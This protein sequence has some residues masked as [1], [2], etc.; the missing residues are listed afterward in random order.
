MANLYFTFQNKATPFTL[1][2]PIPYNQDMAHIARAFGLMP[3]PQLVNT[4]TQY[5]ANLT[6]TANPNVYNAVF[7]AFPTTGR[8]GV[9]LYLRFPSAPVGTAIQIS[10]TVGTTT[11]GPF[12]IT[13]VSG[14]AYPPG[15]F[16]GDV[17][18][19]TVFRDN[20]T[21]QLLGAGST[22]LSAVAAATVSVATK[23]TEATNSA[24]TAASA[25]MAAQDSANTILFTD[26]PAVYAQIN[27]LAL[28]QATPTV[29]GQVTLPL[30]V[31]VASPFPT[32]ALR[33][34]A[35]V[36]IYQG[37]LGKAAINH[38]HPA[39][40]IVPSGAT[41]DARGFVQLNSTLTSA[42]VTQAAT[43]SA[44]NALLGVLN[45]KAAVNHTHSFDAIQ[46]P[47]ATTTTAGIVQLSDSTTSTSATLASTITAMR[48]VNT[49]LS[50]KADV[51]HTHPLSDVGAPSASTSQ[52]GLVR[53]NDTLVSTST[54]L[55][56]TA[57]QGNVLRVAVNGKADTVH[58]HQWADIVSGVPTSSPSTVNSLIKIVDGKGD[59]GTWVA[60]GFPADQGVSP[61]TVA[62]LQRYVKDFTFPMTSNPGSGVIPSVYMAVLRSQSAV[63]PSI[64]KGSSQRQDSLG[65]Y[66]VG[67]SATGQLGASLPAGLYYCVN[68]CANLNT[69]TSR[70]GIWF[71]IG[72]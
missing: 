55:A 3:D 12:P 47:G 14:S 71:R 20:T 32:D 33:H 23:A 13:T 42:A 60:G 51:N 16:A 65:Y 4:G 29:K 34:G 69:T 37:S 43:A 48:A 58:T 44:V 31:P 22:V 59:F 38:T 1:I 54:T 40:D 63:S 28:I 53:L 46:S 9:R 49:V 8:A 39:T 50:G 67:C 6:A 61:A 45:G 2:D 15:T 17:V 41:T 66:L 62:E 27:R 70:P 35:A 5:Y 19:E 25:A 11:Y 57:N 30:S 18:Y 36:S 64:S 68:D 26:Y 52:S 21:M 72:D 56:L 7:D 10:V 24:N